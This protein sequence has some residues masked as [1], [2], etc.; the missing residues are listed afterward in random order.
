M[1][2]RRC[3]HGRTEK[4]ICALCRLRSCCCDDGVLRINLNEGR[5]RCVK[6]NEYC[7]VYKEKACK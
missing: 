7:Q 2:K 4:Q 1:T 6:C 5:Y 3:I